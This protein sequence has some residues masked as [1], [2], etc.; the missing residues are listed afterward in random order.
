VNSAEAPPEGKA[1]VRPRKT[2]VRF[3][4]TQNDCASPESHGVENVVGLAD[5]EL[6]AMAERDRGRREPG[7]QGEDAA[8]VTLLN[9]VE[10]NKTLYSAAEQ[11]RA[12]LARRIQNMIGH[13]STKDFK[14]IVASGTILPNCPI[15]TRDIAAAEDIFGPSLGCLKGKTTRRSSPPV[16]HFEAEPVPPALLE[17]HRDVTL[18]VD[19]M[20]VNKIP[21][22]VT[23]SR[24]L[25]FGT[26]ESLRERTAKQILR[27]IKSVRGVYNKR[28]FRVHTI[29]AD[30]EFEPLRGSLLEDEHGK[31]Q[32]DTKSRELGEGADLNIAGNDEHVPQVERYIRTIKERARGM[33]NTLPFRKI[34][35]VMIIEMVY[36]SVFW[37]NT[38]PPVDGVTTMSPRKLIAGQ[39]LNYNKHCRLEFGAYTQTHEVHDNS[40]S[41]R[42]TGAIALRPTGNQQGGYFFMSLAT[43][44]RLNR[45]PKDWTELPMPQEVIDRVHTLARR[46]KA[47]LSFAWRDGSAI[48]D[49]EDAEEG[50]EDDGDYSPVDDDD[51][52]DIE[53]DEIEYDDDVEAEI[54]TG[55]AGEVPVAAAAP[56]DGRTESNDVAASTLD[57]ETNDAEPIAPGPVDIAEPSTEMSDPDSDDEASI[58][59]PP[60]KHEDEEA[61]DP[62]GPPWTRTTACGNERDC[63]PGARGT[64]TTLTGKCGAPV[65]RESPMHSW[66]TRHSRNTPSRRA[67]RSSDRQVSMR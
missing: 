19:I 49:I 44:R 23:I 31:M 45:K 18:S 33:R 5:H 10:E 53:Y 52:S 22:L 57:P 37:L 40:M 3:Q 17:R 24:Y 15:T 51:D 38:V 27:C 50:D 55:D 6:V 64:T 36:A 43:G 8:G 1:G 67:C 29:L 46:S 61:D 63:A 13:P 32:L 4:D 9:T 7:E 16:T 30:G 47:S 28:G 25:K 56:N 60:A 65:N 34:P 39:K 58:G 11:A 35:A 66:N 59:N 26:V 2:G 41:E 20:F 54:P 42:T 21:F 14:R 62:A 48:I 12:L